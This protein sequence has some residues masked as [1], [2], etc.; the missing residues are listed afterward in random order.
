MI[1]GKSTIAEYERIYS[2]DFPERP[3]ALR[4][5]LDAISNKFNISL[6]HYRGQ[7]GDVGQVLMGFEAQDVD[8]LELLLHKAGYQYER[9][10]S[11]SINIFL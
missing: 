2:F 3:G 4:D 1:G 11:K 9:A 8:E 7:G 5:F 6:F 10:R